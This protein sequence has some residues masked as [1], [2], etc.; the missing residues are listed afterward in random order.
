MRLLLLEN[1][2][3]QRLLRV[4]VHHRHRGLRND[5]AFIH[6]GRHKMNRASVNAHAVGQSPFV[7]MQAFVARQK[8]R[9]DIENP[10][11][12]SVHEAF[13]QH[14]HEAGEA[15]QID[16]VN[17]QHGLHAGFEFSSPRI[18]LVVHR[19]RWETFCF[20]GGKPGRV[21]PIG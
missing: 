10:A 9:V 8:G 14:P 13:C 17:V 11:S 5:R 6:A 19:R 4:V 16:S 18:D 7:R 15:E 12:P 21:R 20:R 1:P 3:A 2:R